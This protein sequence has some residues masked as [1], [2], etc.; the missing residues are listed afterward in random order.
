MQWNPI[1]ILAE[2]PASR[3]QKRRGGNLTSSTSTP[4]PVRGERRTGPITYGIDQLDPGGVLNRVGGFCSVQLLRVPPL[5]ETRAA[6]TARRRTR[7]IAAINVRIK[8]A[9][10]LTRVMDVNTAVNIFS[11]RSGT[12]NA[13]CWSKPNDSITYANTLVIYSM[14]SKTYR[15]GALTEWWFIYVT[16][17][18]RLSP[19]WDASKSLP[20]L[21]QSARYHFTLEAFTLNINI[22]TVR[23]RTKVELG[24]LMWQSTKDH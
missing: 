15:L 8:A 19:L 18:Q 2:T 20:P 23:L 9:R 24:E 5:W 11:I 4:A 22:I 10:L 13:D 1:Y 7:L 3:W 6:V 16:F 17:L 12:E 21:E 14:W